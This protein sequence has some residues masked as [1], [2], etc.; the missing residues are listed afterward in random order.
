M[1][2]KCITTRQKRSRASDEI[3]QHGPAVKQVIAPLCY[4]PD[5]PPNKT[6]PVSTRRGKTITSIQRSD[7]FGRTPIVLAHFSFKYGEFF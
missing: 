5:G 7:L 3:D 2:V 1:A 4:N 6:P